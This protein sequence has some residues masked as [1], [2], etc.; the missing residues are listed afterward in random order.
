M[1]L[2]QIQYQSESQYQFKYQSLS[3]Y[4]FTNFTNRVYIAHN[5]IEAD[6]LFVKE[7][8]IL[9]TY[10]GFDND[11]I[12]IMIYSNNNFD[13]SLEICGNIIV[14][15]TNLRIFKLEKG[16]IHSTYYQDIK[17]VYHVKNNIFTWDKIICVLKKIR[18]EG[19]PEIKDE[20]FKHDN[21]QSYGVYY[22][23]ACECMCKYITMELK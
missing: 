4:N 5:T 7:L 3:H 18:K 2:A 10:V 14:G 23:D 6:Y 20:K 13:P 8:N 9:K 21:V 22:S 11:E 19:E 15:L 1:S 16:V 17:N 12:L